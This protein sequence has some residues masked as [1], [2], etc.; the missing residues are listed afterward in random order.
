MYD[1][2]LVH[3]TSGATNQALLRSRSE[4][5]LEARQ[6]DAGCVCQASGRRHAGLRRLGETMA[7]SAAWMHLST[8]VRSQA[9]SGSNVNWRCHAIKRTFATVL[10]AN[11]G[12]AKCLPM[13]RLAYDF[14]TRTLVAAVIGC[15][16]SASR[17]R[18][19]RAA[20]AHVHNKSMCTVKLR[21]TLNL[22]NLNRAVKHG[23]SSTK[24]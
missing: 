8:A 11:S 13:S 22:K 15:I 10:L 24:Y 5:A 16:P 18:A 20:N 3:S 4:V 19:A 21:L 12:C 17:W 23:F 7:L 2:R 6:A 1:E 14:I 9:S